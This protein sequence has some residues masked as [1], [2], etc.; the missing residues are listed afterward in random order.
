MQWL[1]RGLVRPGRNCRITD[2]LPIDKQRRNCQR[3][4]HVPDITPHQ[5]IHSVAQWFNDQKLLRPLKVDLYEPGTRLS[6]DIRS[7]WPDREGSVV[8]EVDRF[9]GGG[10]AGQV[11]RVKIME[12]DAPDGPL[13]DLEIGGVYAMK[14]LKPPKPMA[15]RFRDLIYKLGFQGPFTIQVNP[16]AARAGALWQ[17]FIRRAA[18]EKFGSESHV[19]DIHATFIDPLIG[20]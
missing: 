11:Y 1:A 8:L 16:T 19:A 6:Y 4:Q 20:A 2:D 17:K 5:A 3:E 13:G 14:L 9:V 7:V 18:A 15:Q 10:Y 12:M